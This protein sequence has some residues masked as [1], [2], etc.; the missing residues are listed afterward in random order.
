MNRPEAFGECIEVERW[1]V[2][3][4]GG[5]VAR[6]LRFRAITARSLSDLNPLLPAACRTVKSE[7]LPGEGKAGK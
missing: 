2:L 1:Q 5:G 7:R 6:W 3:G 4:D